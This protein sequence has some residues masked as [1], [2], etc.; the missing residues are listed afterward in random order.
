MWPKSLFVVMALECQCGRDRSGYPAGGWQSRHRG[1][2]TDSPTSL[3]AWRSRHLGW[4]RPIIVL[5]CFPTPNLGSCKNKNDCPIGTAILK[6]Y[7]SITE[8]IYHINIFYASTKN[9]SCCETSKPIRSSSSL[10]RRGIILS[11]I[12]NNK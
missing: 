8:L 10:T 1:V 3:K 5:K 12:N 11:E 9:S 2:I 7:K 4:C 6:T